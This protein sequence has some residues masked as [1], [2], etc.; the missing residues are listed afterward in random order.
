MPLP[1][2]N[3]TQPAIE[4][5]NLHAQYVATI[6][7]AH[8]SRRKLGMSRWTFL[9]SLAITL[10]V[11]IL[12]ALAGLVFKAITA[13]RYHIIEGEVRRWNDT[14]VSY[15]YG[16]PSS[17]SLDSHNVQLVSSATALLVAV[18]FTVM[19]VYNVR[20]GPIEVL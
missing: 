16:Y 13:S 18:V 12:A 15:M 3:D 11:L 6:H 20:K 7:H 4:M 19:M 8:K 10:F 5:A 9:T 14:N 1:L 17:L 2:S